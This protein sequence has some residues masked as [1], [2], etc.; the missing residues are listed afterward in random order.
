[1]SLST[2]FQFVAAFKAIH[3]IR[4]SGAMGAWILLA[5]GFILQGIR[6]AISLAHVLSGQSTGDM[7]VEFL[8]LAI[9]LF[10]VL[11]IWKFGP[12]FSE[13]RCSHQEQLDKQAEL[14]KLNQQLE[15][16][17]QIRLS[18]EQSLKESEKLFRT[19]ADYTS[20]WEFWL[21][22]DES[23][24]YISPS[25]EI[26]TGYP[27]EE[28][29]RDPR[30]LRKIIHPDDMEIFNNH[31][32]Q[33]TDKGYPKPVDFRI[34]TRDGEER[35]IGHSCRQ[36]FADDGTPA[37]WRASNR[38]ISDRKRLEAQLYE[39]NAGLEQVVRS[40]TTELETSNK[41]L[42][43]FCYSISHELRAPIARLEGFSTVIAECAA[44][45]PP[46]ELSGLAKRI[47][48][49]S[50]RMRA[51]VDALL[52]RYRITQHEM[53]V[54]Q[55]NLSNM[56]RHIVGDLL[57]HAGARTIKVTISPHV[58]VQ[59]DRYLLGICMRNLLG[60]AFQYT[61]KTADAVIEFGR[62]TVSGTTVYFVRDNGVGF[63]MAFY[64]KLFEPFCRLHTDEEFEGNGVGLSTVQKII[65][66][67]GGKIWAEAE[68]GKGA[69]FYFTLGTI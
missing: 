51:V 33:L 5:C 65:Q 36:V 54:E 3:L 45:G 58:V 61:S 22:P 44:S 27:P 34:I 29:Y 30:L 23:F 20:E 17:A 4:V 32:H 7:T 18:I 2:V 1:M 69:I 43:S 24:R 21:G 62:T 48:I 37:G 25:C 57:E 6:R 19:V 8:G 26:L 55:I 56:C 10:M 67:H 31:R 42:E 59:G 13:I 46:E 38:E 53:I 12:L 28:F 66:R 52:Q 49:A 39:F 11:G 15:E 47:G 63:D 40:R 16:E 9:T 41:E 14:S 60:N 64:D 50:R 68:E 35:W